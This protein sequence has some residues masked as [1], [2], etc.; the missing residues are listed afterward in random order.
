ME[1]RASGG[2]VGSM[3]PE[4]SIRLPD[5]GPMPAHGLDCRWRL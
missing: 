5:E 3:G 1:A 2:G 4:F